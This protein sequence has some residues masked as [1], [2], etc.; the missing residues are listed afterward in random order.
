MTQ[1]LR[2]GKSSFDFSAAILC[3]YESGQQEK[4]QRK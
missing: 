1:M 3:E 2:A 4:K